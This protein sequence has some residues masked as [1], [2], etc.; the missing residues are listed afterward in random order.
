MRFFGAL[1][2]VGASFVFGVPFF[3][4]LVCFGLFFLITS[5]RAMSRAVAIGSSHACTTYAV[6]PFSSATQP[7]SATPSNRPNIL[8]E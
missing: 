2:F 3:F 8:M 4:G 6:P 5:S 1:F 7:G